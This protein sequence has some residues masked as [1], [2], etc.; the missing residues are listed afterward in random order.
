[1]ACRIQN[2]SSVWDGQDRTAYINMRN[3]GSDT[4]S[5]RSNIGF[6]SFGSDYWGREYL[7]NH[8]PTAQLWARNHTKQRIPD[9]Y[10]MMYKSTD[11]MWRTTEKTGHRGD[12]T[13]LV[14]DA[15]LKVF[16]S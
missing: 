6:G 9:I 10:K 5:R 13:I 12:G 11:G 16:I 4:L 1:M 15:Q 7:V 2:G 3:W 8:K 14:V